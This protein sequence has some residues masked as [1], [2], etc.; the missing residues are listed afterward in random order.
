MNFTP[1]EQRIVDALSPLIPQIVERLK[2]A[3]VES[4]GGDNRAA[5]SS[6]EA[7]RPHLAVLA[8][9]WLREADALEELAHKR[10][11][12]FRSARLWEQAA[13]KRDCARSIAWV[14]R[15]TLT[16]DAGTSP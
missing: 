15:L 10:G 16:S 12:L 6:E 14:L 9:R 3:E 7:L 11:F 5:S 2:G 4:L 13:I 8:T 1:E